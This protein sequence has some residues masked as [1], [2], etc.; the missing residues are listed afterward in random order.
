LF[1]FFNYKSRWMYLFKKEDM[2]RSINVNNPSVIKFISDITN[3]IVSNIAVDHYFSLSKDKKMNVLYAV[4][5]IIKTTSETRVRLDDLQFRAFLSALWK[6][7]EESEN[8]E[9]AAILFDII[10]NYE[11]IK[12]F[13][14]PPVKRRRKEPTKGGKTTNG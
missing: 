12:E 2:D 10:N 8:Y 9:I 7:N 11:A 6:R 1:P 3:T 5:K 13:I 4:F 14:K